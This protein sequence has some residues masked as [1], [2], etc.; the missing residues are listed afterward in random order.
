MGVHYMVGPNYRLA[1]GN[2]KKVS[3][4]NFLSFAIFVFLLLLFFLLSL[5]VDYTRGSIT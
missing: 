4:L 5:L 1:K 2:Q 3:C